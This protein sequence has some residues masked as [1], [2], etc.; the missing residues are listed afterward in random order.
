M[1]KRHEHHRTALTLLRRMS[2]A[3]NETRSLCDCASKY[4]HLIDQV[5]EFIAGI[6][7]DLDADADLDSDWRR[8]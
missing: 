1:E 5:D 4:D 6:D 3:W 8:Q 7:A 2:A